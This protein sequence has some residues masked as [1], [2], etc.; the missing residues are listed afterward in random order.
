ML[1]PSR[2]TNLPKSTAEG[3]I[4]KISIGETPKQLNDPVALVGYNADWPELFRREAQRVATALGSRALEIERVGST[5]VPGLTAKPI[6]DILL[7]VA[8]SADER[9]YV[10]ALEAARFVLRV[11][12]P[13][14]HEHRLFKGPGTP[15]NLHVFTRGDDEIERMLFFRDW[16]RKNPADRELYAR[17]KREL[18][19]LNWKQ[20]QNYADAK[21]KVVETIITRARK[22]NHGKKSD[23]QAAARKT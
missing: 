3:Q 11:G 6:I 18:A 16:L 5:S 8:N 1:A 19:Q 14:W 2:S 22:K 21:S 23:R 17:T 4:S 7:V 12:E 9:S 15:I 13:H 20:V 10:P